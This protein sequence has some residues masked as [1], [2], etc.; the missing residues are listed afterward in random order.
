MKV[1]EGE[2]TAEY[3]LYYGVD[4]AV[5]PEQATAPK[6]Q[7]HFLPYHQISQHRALYKSSTTTTTL[8]IWHLP[9]RLVI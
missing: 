8:I 2:K 6:S 5:P 9:I 1:R 7:C 3:V 4:R